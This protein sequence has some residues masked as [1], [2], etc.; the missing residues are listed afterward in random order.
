MQLLK[1]GEFWMVAQLL[2]KGRKKERSTVMYA[3]LV[4]RDCRIA[5]AEVV[6]S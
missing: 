5:N 1:E 6:V 4:E 3:S 2:G